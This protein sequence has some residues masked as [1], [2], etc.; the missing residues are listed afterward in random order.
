MEKNGDIT[1]STG[2]LVLAATIAAHCGMMPDECVRVKEPNVCKFLYKNLERSKLSEYRE[3]VDNNSLMVEPQAM[4]T[5]LRNLK[6]MLRE[7]T[8]ANAE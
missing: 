7:A 2:N 4:A 5:A 3:Q 6:V 8:S 1:A